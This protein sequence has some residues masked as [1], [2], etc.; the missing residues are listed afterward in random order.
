[1]TRTRPIWSKTGALTTAPIGLLLP[2]NWTQLKIEV[3]ARA[4]AQLGNAYT[5][6]AVAAVNGIH[7][8]SLRGNATGGTFL[9]DVLSPVGVTV[10][11]T[12]PIPYNES[13]ANVKTALVNTGRFVAGDITAAGGALPT[14][15]TLTWTGVL[16][17]VIPLLQTRDSLTGTGNPSTRLAVTTKPQGNGGYAYLAAGTQEVWEGEE[18]GPSGERYLYLAAVGGAGNYFLSAYR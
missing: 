12:A 11:T 1:M 16:A 7:T 13:A 3:D 5:P 6:P 2:A 14:D 15:I 8:L 9:I 17:G 10:V 4:F 18:A